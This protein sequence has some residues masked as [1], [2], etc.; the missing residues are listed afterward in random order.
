[1]P[2]TPPSGPL[3][4]RRSSPWRRAPRS[5]HRHRTDVAALRPSTARMRSSPSPPWPFRLPGHAAGK[6]APARRPLQL[7]QFE[8]TGAVPGRPAESGRFSPVH[9]KRPPEPAPIR[10]RSCEP[11]R[12]HRTHYRPAV[13]LPG[14]HPRPLP[15]ANHSARHFLAPAPPTSRMPTRSPTR[16]ARW[17]TPTPNPPH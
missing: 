11:R 13:E 10:T 17:W 4:G 5:S 2:T 3:P 15:I 8:P 7:Q 6:R 12:C 16:R 9:R 1:V 14:S